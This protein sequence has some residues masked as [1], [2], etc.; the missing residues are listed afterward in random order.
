M[1]LYAGITDADWFRYLRER[2]AEEMN[3][4]ALGRQPNSRFSSKTNYFYSNLSIQKV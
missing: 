3:F 4:G 2:N 1:K